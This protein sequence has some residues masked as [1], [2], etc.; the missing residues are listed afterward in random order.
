MSTLELVR[1]VKYS[2]ELDEDVF[3]PVSDGEPMAETDEHA[4]QMGYCKDALRLFFAARSDVYVSGNNFLYWEKG[5]PSS[6]ISPDGYV[7][8]GVE[9]HLRDTYLLWEEKGVTPSFVLEVTSKKTQREDKGKKWNIYQDT[10]KVPE[11]FQFDVTG[12]Y[13]NPNLQGWRLSRGKY[14]PI[15]P[16]SLREPNRLYSKALG[17]FLVAE[18]QKMRFYDPISKRY[19]LS[20]IEQAERIEASAQTI[21]SME[22]RMEQETQARQEAE[23][24]AAMEAQR[25]A[26]EL[27]ARQAAESELA[28]MKAE[29][30]AL[31]RMMDQRP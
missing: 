15:R 17:L 1:A 11:Y 25:A 2:S 24:L 16:T 19:L 9:N 30:D 4:D 22:R 13:L 28:R 8:F 27:E 21:G 31:R 18:G 20:Y 12:D 26:K 3:Y 23:N 29:M 14:R 5:A 7:C 6:V 10:L